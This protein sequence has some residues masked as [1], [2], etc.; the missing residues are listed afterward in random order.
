MDQSERNV[1]AFFFLFIYLFIFFFV[2]VRG[3]RKIFLICHLLIFPIEQ[4]RNLILIVFLF[5][6][7]VFVLGQEM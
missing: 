7:V 1:K 2:L 5:A 6:L 4:Q 3:M